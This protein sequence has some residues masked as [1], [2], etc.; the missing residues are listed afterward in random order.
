MKEISIISANLFNDNYSKKFWNQYKDIDLLCFQEYPKYKMQINGYKLYYNFLSHG[1]KENI[2]IHINKKSKWKIISH[3]IIHDES[4][5]TKR[6]NLI[7]QCK[8]ILSYKIINI[9]IVHLCGGCIDDAFAMEIN[10]LEKLKHYK[11]NVLK[12]MIGVDIILGDFNSDEL[13]WKSNDDEMTKTKKYLL[14]HNGATKEKVNLWTNAPFYYLKG[15]ESLPKHK[16]F[17]SFIR[18][19]N[20]YK[21]IFFHDKFTT[22]VYDNRPDGIWI[23]EKH[24]YSVRQLVDL[25]SDEISDH[26]GLLATITFN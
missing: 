25:I 13:S 26:N 5:L 1:K 11:I 2:A 18:R 9:G 17:K 21:S 4:D 7:I 14:Q 24:K 23:L 12:K 16:L 6:L 19:N 15:L 3:Q 22:S 20:F 8:H 10:D